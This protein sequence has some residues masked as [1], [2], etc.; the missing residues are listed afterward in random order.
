MSAVMEFQQ[1]PVP[2]AFVGDV[3][4]LV[5]RLMADNGAAE[6]AV[7]E[8]VTPEE[9]VVE[10]EA[11]HP[12][13]EMVRRIYEES[14]EPHQRLLKALA[15]RPDEWVFSEELAEILH[16]SSGRASLAGSLGAFGKRAN[17]RYNGQKPFTSVWDARDAHTYQAKHMMTAEVAKVINAL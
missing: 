2:H 8:V 5:A 13:E 14:Y 6:D 4:G 11:E 1:V 7:I 12:T 15:A 10:E 17:H 3:Y 16:L 9:E